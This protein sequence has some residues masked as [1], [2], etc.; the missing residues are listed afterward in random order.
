MSTCNWDYD[1]SSFGR[2]PLWG[3]LQRF[4]NR[5]AVLFVLPQ[6]LQKASFLRLF[7][8][9]NNPA[10]GGVIKALRREGDSN[11]RYS[12]PYGSLANCWFKPLTH[13]SHCPPKLKR[14]RIRS[15]FTVVKKRDKSRK[16]TIKHKIIQP[17]FQTLYQ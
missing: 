1:L 4:N 5:F 9:T 16:T 10:V 17:L 12:Y 3:S 2:D 7:G 13:L 6:I 15:Y 14:R 8:K 11:P